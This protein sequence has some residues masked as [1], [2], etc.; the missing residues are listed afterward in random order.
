MVASEKEKATAQLSAVARL[1]LFA[2]FRAVLLRKVQIAERT[3][4]V[5]PRPE[6]MRIDHE[7]LLA[8]WTSY[9]YSLAHRSSRTI[10][11]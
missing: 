2:D 10:L 3:M 7:N 1:E 5:H 9:L 11:N 6:H 4:K 8:A